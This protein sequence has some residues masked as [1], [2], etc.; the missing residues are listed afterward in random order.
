MKTTRRTTTRTKRKRR[1]AKSSLVLG[2]AFTIACWGL[3]ALSSPAQD[4]GQPQG[5]G[6]P[7]NSR[8]PGKS[9]KDVPYAVLAGTVFRDPGFAQPGATV[10][11]TRKDEPKKKLVEGVSNSRGEFS[12]R[13][14][15]G[16]VTYVVTA[17]LKGFKEE[18]QE[19]EVSG[20]EQVNATLLLIPESKK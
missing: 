18:R 20:E 15:P 17:T 6:P 11:V 9:K 12:F 8:P 7:A 4:R 14:P 2:L 16:P 13:V 10:I 1:T 3:P 19:F 5:G